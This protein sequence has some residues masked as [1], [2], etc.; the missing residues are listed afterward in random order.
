MT[1]VRPSAFFSKGP[2]SRSWQ[3]GTLCRLR[4]KPNQR[5]QQ[6]ETDT[7]L[8]GNLPVIPRGAV[9]L[10]EL[11]LHKPSH[12]VAEIDL[13]HFVLWRWMHFTS[14]PKKLASV[15]LECFSFDTD[16]LFRIE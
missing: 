9:E 12:H 1:F 16:E 4:G 2:A 7:G 14:F 5:G 13:M 10:D 6:G 3:T 15:V 8:D 11:L